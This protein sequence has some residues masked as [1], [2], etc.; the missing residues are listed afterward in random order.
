M[1]QDPWRR[2]GRRRKTSLIEGAF[3]TGWNLVDPPSRRHK[4]R[5]SAGISDD[6]S[7]TATAVI[8]CILIALW[9]VILNAPSQ[10]QCPLL[11][12]APIAVAA[13][14]LGLSSW[15]KRQRTS[16]T[17]EALRYRRFVDVD[18]SEFE[19]AI[20]ELFRQRGFDVIHSGRTGDGG[21][22]LK[23]Q[24][25]GLRSIAQCKRY[26]D[27]PVGEPALRDFYGALVNQRG[28][29]GYFITTSRF[30]GPA[31]DFAQYKPITLID[32]DELRH[33][34]EQPPTPLPPPEPVRP[35]APVA[36]GPSAIP[37]VNPSA[38]RPRGDHLFGMTGTQIAV[39]LALLSSIVIVFAVLLALAL[40]GS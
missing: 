20:G 16:R 8:A 2:R 39:L 25:S 33:W 13:V 6:L 29:H 24:R 26:T 36:S 19:H 15:I 9:A 4:R 37:V 17:L 38:P 40:R 18:P 31:R 28:D 32:G 11:A 1:M 3:N 23:M 34:I 21:V 30:T 5:S 12:C 7:C 22:D 10:L 14:V 27:Q 35:P